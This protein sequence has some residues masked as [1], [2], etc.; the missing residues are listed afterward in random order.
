MLSEIERVLKT[1]VSEDELQHAK[2]H[3]S[4]RMMLGLE[5]SDQL[6][7]YYGGQE[8]LERELAAPEDLLHKIR[9][10]TVE[11]VANVAKDI[12]KNEHL[13]LAMIGPHDS[14]D[15]SAEFA[16]ILKLS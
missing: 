12:F 2:D 16:K 11:D 3:L 6:A 8:I 7:M 9:A 15:S 4:G 10:V 1:P 5:T 13:N 14:S